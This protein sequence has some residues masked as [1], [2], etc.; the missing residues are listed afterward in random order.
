MMKGG[1]KLSAKA[2]MVLRT[3]QSVS[4]NKIAA[5]PALWHLGMS[6]S[7]LHWQL[8]GEGAD[9]ASIFIGCRQAG[10]EC[11]EIFLSA[12]ELG[13]AGPTALSRYTAMVDAAR[14]AGLSVWS[15]HLPFGGSLDLSQPDTTNRAAAVDLLTACIRWA[16]QQGIA[17]AVVHPS[18]EPIEPAA[19][20][21]RLA[22]SLGSLRQLAGEAQ[23]AGVT[24][25]VECLPRTCLGNTS[26]E[27]AELIAG[28]GDLPV[29]LDTNHLLQETLAAFIQ[30]LG[31]RLRTLHISDYDG[32]DEKHWLPGMGV[33][34]WV[35]LVD[36]LA[37][38]GYT[39]PFLFE[40]RSVIGE[41]KT[42]PADLAASWRTIQASRRERQQP[43]ALEG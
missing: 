43:I 6:T 41:Q 34:D 35:E 17:T 7:T 28:A 15:T 19:R 2:G 16:G 38:A 18:A 27:L 30:R 25:A 40:V 37:G 5:D 23:Q 26:A 33:I 8:A 21:Q 4:N 29:C 20:Q 3:R 24:L 1:Y 13:A 14:A 10:I 39:G 36:L 11:L 42:T 12:K 9:L 32:L 31:S 22:H